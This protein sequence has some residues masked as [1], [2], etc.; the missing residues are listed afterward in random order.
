MERESGPFSVHRYLYPE[1]GVPTF[2]GAKVAIWPEDLVAGDV[3]VA[4]MG[5]PSDMSSG[6]RDA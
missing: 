6:Q 4:I 5:V 3:D 2:G 1:S